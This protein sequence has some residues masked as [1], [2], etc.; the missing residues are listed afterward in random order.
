MSISKNLIFPKGLTHYFGLYPL[1][2]KATLF[3]PFRKEIL[4]Y[5]P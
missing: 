4:Q 2:K 3:V 1:E 5:S